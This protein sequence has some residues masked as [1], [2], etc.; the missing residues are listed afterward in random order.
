MEQAAVIGWLVFGSIVMAAACLD[1]RRGQ[2]RSRVEKMLV[3]ETI[4][5]RAEEMVSR[6]VRPNPMVRALLGLMRR[7]SR[8]LPVTGLAEAEK[9]LLWAGNPR[10]LSPADFYSAKVIAA[11]LGFGFLASLTFVGA[12]VMGLFLSG[13]AAFAGYSLPDV[14]LSTLVNQ[15]KREVDRQII[16]FTD[17]LA[18]ATE[19]GLS[20]NDAVARVSEQYGGVLGRE[21]QRAFAQVQGGR[22]LTEALEDLAARNPSD[23]LGLLVSALV[24][25]TKMGTPVVQVLREQAGQLRQSKRNRAQEVAQKA[26]V[27]ML[28]PIIAFIFLPMMVLILGPAIS[29][30]GRALGL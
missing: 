2:R 1:A 19:A 4:M 24:Q 17:M 8:Y 14:W 11:V 30:L 20:L 27:K 12:G 18:I 5:E 6:E 26:S 21:F 13:F 15:R 25:A 9:R 29:N 7:L 23:D 3:G 10:N 28:M 16:T 22:P